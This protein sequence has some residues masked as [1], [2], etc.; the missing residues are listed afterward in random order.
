M[1]QHPLRRSSLALAIASSLAAGA[2][3][4]AT[5]TVDTHLDGPVGQ[6]SSDCSLRAAIAS[7]NTAS[8][9]DGCASGSPVGDQI[10]FAPA[11]AGGEI[12]LTHGEMLI[13]GPLNIA[14][15]VPGDATGI[16]INGDN[17]IFHNSVVV[18]AG[19]GETACGGQSSIVFDSGSLATDS[20]CICDDPQ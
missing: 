3:Q 5:I 14:G 10:V 2:L 20:S 19:A 12:V 8:A 13:A 7:A 1:K 16:T 17:L 9:V 4:A 15:P 11:L 6:G 18:P